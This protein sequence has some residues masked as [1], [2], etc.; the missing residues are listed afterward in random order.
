MKRVLTIMA[1][2][3]ADGVCSAAL[4]KAALA[5]DYDEVRIYFTH[6]VDLVKDFREAAAGDVY[7][8]D[9]A[10]DEK[11]AGEA[12]E[13]FSRYTGRV[14]YIDH[15]P[16]SVDLPGVEVVHEEGPSAS[17]LVYRRLAGRLPRAYTR[18]ALYGAISDYMDY[19]EW[20][21]G[22]LERW[23]KRIVYYEAG[24]LMQGLERA[25]K[26]HE[27]KREV[28][29]HLARNGAPSAMAKLLKLAE[30]Q[31]RVNEALV[32]WV[33]KNASVEGE[34]AYVINPPGPLGL[35]ANLARGLKDASVGL[36]AEERGEIYVMSLRS[37]AEVDLNAFLREF[38]RRH[39]ASGGGH[40]NAAGARIPRALLGDL[41]RE[42]NL[43][44]SRQTRGQASSQ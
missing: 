2:G 6:P 10:I 13:V 27:F 21:R 33:E 38:A 40:K 44:I 12:R 3:D 5:G 42:L 32:G 39:S 8:V 9:V 29:S 35:A 22:A 15:H 34:V 28:V 23:D 37:S 36:A 1:H 31:A 14:V 43:Y 30:E 25:R 16:L 4:V 17:E 11:I 41:L 26:D 19:T 20:V 7:I 24:V 18:V